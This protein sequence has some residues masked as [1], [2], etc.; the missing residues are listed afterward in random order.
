MH[1]GIRIRQKFSACSRLSPVRSEPAITVNRAG[2]NGG[3]EKQ[4]HEKIDCTRPGDYAVPQAKHDVECAKCDVRNSQKSK[5]RL[6]C[7]ERNHFRQCQR[8]HAEP[9]CAVE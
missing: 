3:K 5:L 8:K 9:D 4:K 6:R 1:S 7:D 2:G